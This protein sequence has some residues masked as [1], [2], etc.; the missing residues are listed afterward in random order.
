ML[1]S[2]STPLTKVIHV[3]NLLRFL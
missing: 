2:A 1:R 3:A